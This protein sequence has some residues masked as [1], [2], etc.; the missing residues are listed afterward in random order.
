[1]GLYHWLHMMGRDIDYILWFCSIS[2]TFLIEADCHNFRIVCPI[3]F[4]QFKAFDKL[5]M[6]QATVRSVRSARKTEVQEESSER[7]ISPTES[8]C[9]GGMRVR[10]GVVGLR[11]N[12]ARVSE[13]GRLVPRVP[14]NLWS[15]LP[16]VRSVALR[17]IRDPSKR[18]TFLLFL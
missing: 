18:K 10:G 14:E 2:S 16:D 4:V 7:N 13:I 15:S 17:W 3:I 12:M 11:C 8:R 1:M 5:W 6:R 9:D